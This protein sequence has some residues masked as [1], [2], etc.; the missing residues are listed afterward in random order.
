[1]SKGEHKRYILTGR[2]HGCAVRL[3][4][5]NLGSARRMAARLEQAEIYDTWQNKSVT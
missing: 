4:Y 1:M 2:E 3:R 5:H